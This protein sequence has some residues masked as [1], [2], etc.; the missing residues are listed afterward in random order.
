MSLKSWPCISFQSFGHISRQF[1]MYSTPYIKN[2]SKLN[3]I[4]LP[5]YR[6]F[7]KENL[8]ILIR[9][10]ISCNG[11]SVY[12]WIIPDKKLTNLTINHKVVSSPM[13]AFSPDMKY[14]HLALLTSWISTFNTRKCMHAKTLLIIKPLALPTKLFFRKW[15]I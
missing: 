4:F 13:S 11:V 3:D 9:L 7:F 10:C 5:L 1:W 15:I 12:T 2:F 8:V 6:A 14:K